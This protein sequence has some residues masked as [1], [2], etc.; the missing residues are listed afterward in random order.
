MAVTSGVM[1]AG[2]TLLLTDPYGLHANPSA[3]A[4]PSTSSY[5]NSFT[6]TTTPSSSSSTLL[7]SGLA[8]TRTPTL[9]EDDYYPTDEYDVRN[10][11]L[12]H[13]ATRLV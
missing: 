10:T 8:E 3:S 4:P 11:N 5:S 13:V 7:D 12:W 1:T 6:N 9:S 2:G